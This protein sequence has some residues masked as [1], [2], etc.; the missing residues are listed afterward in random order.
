MLIR[1]EFCDET[2]SSFLIYYLISNE[3][4]RTQV[5]LSGQVNQVNLIKANA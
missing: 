2:L 5:V 1:V 4:T 3:A